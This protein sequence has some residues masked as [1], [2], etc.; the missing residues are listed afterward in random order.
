MVVVACMLMGCNPGELTPNGGGVV[1]RA[2]ALSSRK[3]PQATEALRYP[4][5][6]IIP[7]QDF[8]PEGIAHAADGTF[9][10]GSANTG[11]VVRQRPGSLW[12][13]PFLPATG[14][15]VVGM[16][17]QDSTQTLWL[18]ELDL[19]QPTPGALKAYDLATRKLRGSWPIPQEGLCNDLTLDARGNVYVTAPFLGVIHRLRTGGSQLE[20]WAA[21]PRFIPPPGNF[22]LNG[23]AWDDGV[24]YVVKYDSGELFRVGLNADG[25]AGAVTRIT[26]DAPL[27][28]PDGILTLAPGVLL[29]VDND[30]GLLKRVDLSGD[31]GHVTLLAT[32]LDNPT[33]VALHD[34]DA[35]V[36]QSQ[37][38][39]LIG[40]DRTPPDMP[41]VVKRVWL[42]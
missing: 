2:G 25:S 10:I 6:L 4:H 35:F 19:S 36:V 22:G 41:F 40:I 18:C 17:V 34:G 5:K 8:Y 12:A 37:F 24:V 1:S 26:T 11:M 3:A 20:T 9:Y 32:G 7:I 28:F 33:T 23:I 31:T 14:R 29:V 21:D 16:K 30:N 39:H 27:G 13:E 42:R 38:D 15:T